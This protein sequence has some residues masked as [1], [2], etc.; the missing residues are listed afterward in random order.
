[1]TNTSV[2]IDKYDTQKNW[3]LAKIAH[4]AKKFPN[5]IC[6]GLSWVI[7]KR[8]FLSFLYNSDSSSWGFKV[9]FFRLQSDIPITLLGVIVWVGSISRVLVVLQKTNNVVVRCHF[10]EM[11]FML[12]TIF[13]EV[14]FW[15]EEC[16]FYNIVPMGAI[17]VRCLSPFGRSTFVRYFKLCYLAISCSLIYRT[18]RSAR[19]VLIS[20]KTL[21]KRLKWLCN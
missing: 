20:K 17:N 14:V 3:C 21:Q 8:K 19:S 10:C 18:P 9:E 4:L 15:Q 1:M 7:F 13:C 2:E 16:P 5:V 12:G 6:Q 11:Q